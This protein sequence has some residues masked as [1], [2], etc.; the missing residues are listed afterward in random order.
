MRVFKK[1]TN[2]VVGGQREWS[3]H[4]FAKLRITGERLKTESIYG[5]RMFDN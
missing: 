5:G 2:K 3:L 4:R 1:M